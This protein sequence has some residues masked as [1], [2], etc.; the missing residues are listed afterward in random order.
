MSKNFVLITGASSG[1]GHACTKELVQKGYWVFGSV[2]NAEDADRLKSEFQDRF[3][4]LIFDQTIDEQIDQAVKVVKSTLMT[5]DS[6]IAIVN[7]AG[8]V[9]NGPLLLLP[10]ADLQKQLDVNVIGVMRVIQ[11]FFP[12]LM[13]TTKYIGPKRI[14]NMGSTSGLF[15]FPFLGPYCASKYALEALTDSLRRELLIYDIDVVIIEP[16]PVATPIWDKARQDKRFLDTVYGDI[17]RKKEQMIN[18]SEARALPVQV[19][20][21]KVYEMVTESHVPTRSII[22]KKKWAFQI[23]RKLI[24]DR[25]V[26][27]GIRKKLMNGIKVRPE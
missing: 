26:D 5:E 24:P 6:L 12:L 3:V 20:A 17:L 2:R 4:P 22:M 9:I 10:I 19:V 11:K 1:I 27:R 25:W 8:I 13:R 15:T 21:R 23:M 14:V 7:N 18:E 16:G